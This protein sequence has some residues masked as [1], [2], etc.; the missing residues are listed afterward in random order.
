M[1][2]YCVLSLVKYISVNTRDKQNFQIA[3]DG[4]VASGKGTVSKQLADTLGFLYV[5]TGATYRT[6]TLLALRA[7]VDLND[8]AKVVELV[9]Q[10]DIVITSYSIHYTK[11]YE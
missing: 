6:A 10:A 9:R 5:D 2:F 1:R 8:E 4:P 3:I 11:L 7:G